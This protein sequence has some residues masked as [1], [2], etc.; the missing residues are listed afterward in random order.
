MEKSKFVNYISTENMTNEERIRLF[1]ELYET[2]EI[3]TQSSRNMLEHYTAVAEIAKI[4]ITL[5]EVSFDVNNQFIDDYMTVFLE[6]DT[7]LCDFLTI[8][9]KLS[10]KYEEKLYERGYTKEDLKY[11]YI[12]LGCEKYFENKQKACEDAS[13]E[14]VSCEDASF[15]VYIDKI[16][17]WRL[18]LMYGDDKMIHLCEL[19]GPA[20]HD[21]GTQK[22][23]I[24]KK[25]DR[26]K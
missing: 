11:K 22:N 3:L 25:K 9:Q 17:G 6:K 20:E 10:D 24:H 7:S 15:E 8:S 21:R 14:D 26:Y 4:N 18:H 12:Y 19:L 5:A 23:V 1:C 16:S 13:C 2:K